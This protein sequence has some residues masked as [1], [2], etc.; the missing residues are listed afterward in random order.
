MFVP[1][2][3]PPTLLLLLLLPLV[4]HV[5]GFMVKQVPLHPSRRHEIGTRTTTSPTLLLVTNGGTTSSLAAASFTSYIQR[6]AMI[7]SAS[8]L[9][10]SLAASATTSTAAAESSITNG[11]VADLPM[12]RLRLPQG[13]LGREY[14]VVQL[15]VQGK[16]PYDFMLDT[17]L[18]AEFIT[19]HLQRVL[20]LGTENSGGS[21]IT[22]LA[23]GGSTQEHDLILLEGAS[24]C[25]GA[26]A[27]G[28]SEFPLP[29][30]H[31]IITDFPQEHID[32]AHDPVEGMLGMELLSLF[33]VDFDFAAGR[34]RLWKPGTAASVAASCNMVAIPAVVINETGL[35]GIRVTSASSSKQQPILGFLDCGSTFSAIN[36]SAAR[37]LG[38]P[39]QSDVKYYGKGP[40]VAAVGIDGR[41][42]RLPTVSKQITFAGDLVKDTQ[43]GR[44]MG[45]ASP[46]SNWEPWDETLVAVGDLP[47]FQTILGDGKT[48]YKGPAALIGLDVLAQRRV[49]L[50]TGALGTRPR[51]VF[52]EPTT[53][54]R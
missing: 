29:P 17:G 2:S 39:D 20:R 54:S 50:E 15:K 33:D 32:P 1:C 41:P 27:E 7:I 48:P 43:T 38:L 25:C 11:L 52:V 22:G 45:F 3:I 46:P 37:F 35:I 8:G 30:L 23:A 34:L 6:R 14:V 9:I 44:P 19:P 51:R 28:K 13:G 49:I 31:A 36:W 47:A 53:K 10:S 40:V 4:Q 21:K 18:T 26:F 24:L 42:L 12:I 5:F 16:G